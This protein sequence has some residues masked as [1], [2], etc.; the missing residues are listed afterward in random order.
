VFCQG[1][2][3]DPETYIASGTA[4]TALGA[5]RTRPSAHGI[6]S[7]FTIF[8]QKQGFELGQYLRQT[9]GNTSSP[10]YIQDLELDPFKASQI[11]VRADAG[12][13][14]GVIYDTTLAVTQ[15]IWQSTTKFTST[16]ANGTVVQG[17]MNGYQVYRLSI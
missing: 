15:G 9:Y 6:L 8:T 3:Q 4:I 11:L 12:G 5:V 17:P 1:F 10:S 7:D 14:G 16:L 13:E 2:Y